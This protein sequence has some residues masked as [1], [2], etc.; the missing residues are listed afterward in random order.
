MCNIYIID[1]LHRHATYMRKRILVCSNECKI[2]AE[3][4]LFGVP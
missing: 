1:I 4:E 3:E 2:I